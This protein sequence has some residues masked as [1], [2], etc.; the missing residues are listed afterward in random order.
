MILR[1]KI[2]GLEED[3]HG[4]FGRRT[5]LIQI[6][7]PILIAA[8]LASSRLWKRGANGS[9]QTYACPTTITMAAL[10]RTQQAAVEGDYQTLR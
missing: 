4:L 10:C 6:P 3:R 5:I 7:I 9:N 2:V 1:L 8:I